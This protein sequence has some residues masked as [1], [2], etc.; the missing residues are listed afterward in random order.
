MVLIVF[1]LVFLVYWGYSH[2]V[3]SY[4][5]EGNYVVAV[6]LSFLFINAANGYSIKRT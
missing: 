4:A 6:G 2:V 1:V 5:M 3:V